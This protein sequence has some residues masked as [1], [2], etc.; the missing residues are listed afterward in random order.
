M[1]RT[2]R[3]ATISSINLRSGSRTAF[4]GFAFTA[5]SAC[6]SSPSGSVSPS[7]STVGEL[8]ASGVEILTSGGSVDFRQVKGV[9]Q[10]PGKAGAA[11]TDTLCRSLIGYPCYSPQEMRTAY[12]VSELLADGFDGKGQTIVIVDSYGSPT[13]DADLRQFDSD[14][15][16]PDPPS[17]QVVSPLGTVEF[18]PTNQ[19]MVGWALETTLDVE[20]AHSMAPGAN[21]VLL[22]SPVS[23]TEGTVGMP[24]FIQIETYAL[25]HHLGQVFSQSWGATENTLMDSAGQDVIAQFEAVYQRARAEHVTVFAGAG[26]SGSANLEQSGTTFYSFPTVNYPASSPWV[27]AVGGTSLTADTSG[28]YISEAVWDDYGAGGGGVSQIFSEPIW[29]LPLPAS[30]QTLLARHRGIPDVSYNADPSTGILVYASLPGLPAGYYLFGGTS[31]GSPQWAGIAA[32][33]NQI[34]GRPLGYLNAKLY[35]LGARGALAPVTHDITVGN[36]GFAG[37]PGYSATPGWDLA[38]GWGT[39]K[40]AALGKALAALPDDDSQN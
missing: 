19:D 15:G 17:F 10:A 25:D 7:T 26:D 4:I 28:N 8:G 32:D 27:T 36:N 29:Q 21:I 16:L 20:W 24:Q 35:L 1:N 11:P 3:V 40:L 31:E 38:T 33:F 2:M 14:Y 13:I 12:G 5:L 23:E 18:D 34:A 6:S 22:T 37:I 9:R 39:P 30:D